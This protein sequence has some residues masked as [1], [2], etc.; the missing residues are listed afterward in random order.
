M[1][2]L[3]LR[4]PATS[5]NLGPCFDT[6]AVAISQFL[7]VEAVAAGEFSIKADG[8]NAEICGRLEDN[9]LLKAYREI[10]EQYGKPIVPLAVTMW[11]EIPLG[12]GCGSS[13]AVLLAAVAFAV[14]FGELGWDDDRILAEACRIEG[15]PDNVAACWLGG[16][17]I[18]AVGE[19]G[20]VRTARVEPPAAWRAV[21]V[22]P[23]TPLP[24]VKA[25]AVLPEQ[26]SRK[27][28]VSNLQAASLMG[29]AWSLGDAALLSMAMRD[30]IH[31]PYRQEICPLLPILLPLAGSNGILGAALS[32][33]GP[34]V[35]LV[36]ESEEY[37]PVVRQAIEHAV[38]TAMPVQIIVSHFTG[39]GARQQR[40]VAC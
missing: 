3:A 23:D 29:L 16:L 7:E 39:D 21:L 25:R 14:H 8:R 18:A 32:G 38:G 2:R 10:L 15:H 4:L 36:L 37:F 13:A 5:A 1:K 19:Q 20:Q 11:N 17:A 31:Q 26:Y 6:A 27:D 35:L 12:M 9:L 40:L 22:L 30:R 28:V 34:A 33:A 24:T